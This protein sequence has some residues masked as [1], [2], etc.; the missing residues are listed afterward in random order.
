M[1]AKVLRLLKGAGADFQVQTGNGSTP[2]HWAA[3]Y[4]R[5]EA[6]KFLLQVDDIKVNI[7]NK[8]G[9]SAVHICARFGKPDVS[10][11]IWGLGG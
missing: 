4:D 7:V 6:V 1:G 3:Q 11:G 8:A 9:H 10:L 2:L 5:M